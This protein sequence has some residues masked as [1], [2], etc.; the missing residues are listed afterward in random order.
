[1]VDDP[2]AVRDLLERMVCTYESP[3]P[4]E[5]RWSIDR[6][7]AGVVTKMAQAVTA[8]EIPISRLEGKQKLSQNRTEADR[9]GVVEGLR[10]EGD[11]LGADAATLMARALAG[12]EGP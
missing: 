12:S 3:R 2:A 9:H 10:R 4:A 11:A 5:R 6:L 7:D 1:V 8:F